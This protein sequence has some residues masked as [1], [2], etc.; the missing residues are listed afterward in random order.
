MKKLVVDLA[1]PAER[2]LYW[3]EGS[4]QNVQAVSRDGRTVRFP[5]RILR[6]YLGHDG[7]HG[8]FVICFDE[9]NRFQSISRID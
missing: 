5:A 2:Y 1:L 7:I 6:P 9:D 4:A 8:S 3:Y